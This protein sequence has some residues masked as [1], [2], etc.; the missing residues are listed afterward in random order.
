VK[1]PQTSTALL[2]RRV[3]PALDQDDHVNA[4]GS[5]GEISAFPWTGTQVMDMAFGPDGALYVL[6]YGTGFGNGDHS[7]L[8]R[9][10]YIGGG[11]R[12]PVA[13]VAPNP[14]SGPRR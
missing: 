11:N 3:R 2:R 4:D 10:E 9:I 12:A 8:Y 13:K 7:A 14:T 5:P 6:D 1:F